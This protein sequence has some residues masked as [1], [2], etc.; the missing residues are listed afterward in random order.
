[1]NMLPIAV[2]ALL[3]TLLP[4][5]AE[6]AADKTA[7]TR[8]TGYPLLRVLSFLLKLSALV[9]V[10]FGF[11]AAFTSDGDSPGLLMLF[12]AAGCI[13]GLLLFTAGEVVRMLTDLAES[14]KQIAEQLL[15]KQQD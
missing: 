10:F 11:L 4:N 13:A 8:K 15:N 9:P 14:S 3:L 6:P 1:M 5:I 12:V 7:Q 2:I